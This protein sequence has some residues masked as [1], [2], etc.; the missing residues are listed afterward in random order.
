MAAKKTKK[1][2]DNKLPE[3][4]R[5][6]GKKIKVVRTDMKDGHFGEYQQHKYRIEIDKKSCYEEARQTLFHECLHAALHISGLGVL[7][8]PGGE[9]DNA[10]D[11]E[12]AVV[13]CLENAFG[14]YID[15]DKLK[16]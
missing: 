7:L 3:Y 15:I 16:A 6:L 9:D 10:Q 2:E 8:N 1:V 13:I 5:V 14:E 4:V 11:L 12:E